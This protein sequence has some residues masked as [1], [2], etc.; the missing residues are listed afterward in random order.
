MS[1]KIHFMKGKLCLVVLTTSKSLL[2]SRRHFPRVYKLAILEYLRCLGDGF[3]RQVGN[4]V[5][6]VGQP[7]AASG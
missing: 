1:E 4:T 3:Y 5:V 7:E 6:V 2:A